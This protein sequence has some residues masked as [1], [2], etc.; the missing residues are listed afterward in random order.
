MTLSK[1]F[2]F[3]CLSF[4]LGVALNSIFYLPQF[5]I[6]GF[7]FASVF[8]FLISYYSK[9][10]IFVLGFSLIFVALGAFWHDLS[11]AEIVGYEEDIEIIGIIS[12]EVDIRNENIRFKLETEKGAFLVVASRYPEYSY[13]D[14]L[15]VEGFL[16]EPSIF[17]GFNYKGYLAK[18]GVSAVLYQPKIKK[19][20]ENKG[21]PILAKI[22]LLKNKLRESVYS[23][24][25]PPQSLIL[26]SLL[27]GDKKRISDN[28]GEKLNI[29]GLR[30]ITAISGMHIA[31]LSV[32]LMQLFVGIGFWRGHAFY[33]TIILLALFII[34]IGMPSSA[35][36]AGL[37]MGFFLFSQKIGRKTSS[38]RSLIFAATI[39]LIAN[40]LL[41]R[42][43]IGFQLSF[44]AVSG[45][46][47]LS[48]LFKRLIR[49]DFLGVRSIISMTLSAQIFTLPLLIYNF[50]NV[51]LIAPLT[52]ILVLPLLPF[53][54]ASGFLF[55]F[56]GILFSPLGNILSWISWLLL[57]YVVK[58]IELFSAFPSIVFKNVHWVWLLISYFFLFLFVWLICKHQKFKFLDYY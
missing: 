24:L 58:V 43:D 51:S 46:I 47:F 20:G 27:L 2:S 4:I 53:I 38:F 22:L 56:L 3:I 17:E 34:M 7:L 49:S 12:E 39:I 54:L 26:G 9:Q 33:L 10:I 25:S 55:S 30:H 40:P 50:G 16:E 15:M 42:F 32:V 18:E 45:I 36:R 29:T 37:M 19:I 44:L 11:L 14:E 52:N 21:N 41:L 57:T 31:I 8:I 5:F 23:R 6:L 48:P 13:G 28:L 1:T 35:Q